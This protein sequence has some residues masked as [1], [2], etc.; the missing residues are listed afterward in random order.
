[1][2]SRL[3][4]IR[5]AVI[6]QK[7]EHVSCDESKTGEENFDVDFGVDSAQANSL[8]PILGE[9]QLGNQTTQPQTA[10][11]VKLHSVY[12][13]DGTIVVH[14]AIYTVISARRPGLQSRS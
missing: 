6:R 11:N 1:M 3:R 12:S 13:L 10:I 9:N 8:Q 5:E 2:S 14:V 4:S 7:E